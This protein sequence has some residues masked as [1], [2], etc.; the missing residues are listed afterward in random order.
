MKPA[1]IIVDMLKDTLK[2]GSR[3]PITQEAKRIIPNLQRLLNESREKGCPIIFACDSFLKE[4]FIFK[5]KMK[6]RSLRGTKDA[7]VVDDLKPEPTDMVLP[8]RRFSAFFKTDLDQTLRTLGVDMIVVTG[9][10]T[11]VCVLMTAMDGLCHDF[12]VILLEDCCASRNSEAHQGCLNL[13]RDFA[14]YPLLRIMTLEEFLK[15]VAS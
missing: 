2:E 10:A 7:E 13:Y 3:F 6:A 11:E 12:S 14:L 5:G 4:D 15:E 8:K 9:I 1:I